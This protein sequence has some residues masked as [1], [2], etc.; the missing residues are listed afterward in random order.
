MR[1]KAMNTKVAP[2]ISRLAERTTRL[3]HCT[4]STLTVVIPCLTK[5]NF[6]ATAWD[7]S[8]IRLWELGP[9]SLTVATT[10]LPFFVFVILILVPHGR[11][12]FAVVSW[13]AT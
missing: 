4:I 7:T 13:D 2:P 12:L 8:T 5:S 9:Q 10:L 11:L 6:S 3:I 1:S